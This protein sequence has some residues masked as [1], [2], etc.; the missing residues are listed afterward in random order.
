MFEVPEIL[1]RPPL[2]AAQT[3]V[4]VVD[5]V[6]HQVTPGRWLLGHHEAEG[7]DVSYITRRVQ[8]TVIPAQQRLLKEARRAGAHVVYL[9]VGTARA[10]YADGLP[11]FRSKY[12]IWEAFDGSPACEVISALKPEPKDTVLLKTGSG[13]FTTSPL[14]LHL[15][16]LNVRHVAYVGV[17]TNACVLLTLAAGFDLGYYGYLISDATATFSQRLQ[18]FTEEIVG[19]YMAKVTSTDQ[20]IAMLGA[21]SEAAMPEASFS[22]PA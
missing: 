14:D 22:H 5:M 3:A 20:F 18:D 17:V 16:N 6:N 19:A 4:V 1:A 11:A 7:K 15:R 2:S 21:P 13:G 8:E 12:P 9:R 10:D